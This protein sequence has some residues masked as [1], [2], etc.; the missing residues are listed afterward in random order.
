MQD[1]KHLLHQFQTRPDSQFAF[2]QCFPHDLPERFHLVV[3]AY[4]INGTLQNGFAQSSS[5]FDQIKW[6]SPIVSV[7]NGLHQLLPHL[8]VLPVQPQRG[9]HG[10]EQT[11]ASA[12][13]QGHW[14]AW[15]ADWLLRPKNNFFR[16]LHGQLLNHFTASTIRSWNLGWADCFFPLSTPLW[17]VSSS[18]WFFV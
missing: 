7:P 17:L 15:S 5:H 13:V 6:S 12:N 18:G 1:S 3:L 2:P 8:R 11:T 4:Q 10:V 9:A 14:V 16:F